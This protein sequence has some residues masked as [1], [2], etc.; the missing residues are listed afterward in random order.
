[1]AL[2]PEGMYLGQFAFPQW[3]KPTLYGAF[4][5]TTKVVP[6]QNNEDFQKKIPNLFAL[7]GDQF[8]VA[9]HSLFSAPAL[10]P[11]TLPISQR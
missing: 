6:F 11:A 3:L 10:T 9:T 4:Y 1:M 7:G 2:A 5:G 8:C